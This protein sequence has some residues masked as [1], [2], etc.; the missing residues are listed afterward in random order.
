[1]SKD[2]RLMFINSL[3]TGN[4]LMGTFANSEDPDEMPHKAADH[5]VLQYLLKQ[6]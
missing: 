4:P 6:K 5:Q 3:R 1:M 2:L